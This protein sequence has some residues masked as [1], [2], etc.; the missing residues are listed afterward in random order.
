MVSEPDRGVSIHGTIHNMS[1]P[2]RI[3]M[4]D[5]VVIRV[6]DL[7]GMV[8]FYCDVLG[9]QVERRQDELGLVQL[10]A[11]SGLIDLIPVDGPLGR[12]G[13]AAPTAEGRNLDHLCLRIG[14]MPLWELAAW[15]RQ[16]GIEPGELAIRY[17]AQGKGPSIYI[18][19]PED[20]RVELKPSIG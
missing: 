10:R 1:C 11:G 17:G 7:E 9:C 19:D 12:A 20:N 16:N 5:H 8:S 14:R 4:I 2:I 18:S 13:G 6:T 3:E 15:L